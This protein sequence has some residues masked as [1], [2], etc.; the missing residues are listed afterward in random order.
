MDMRWP[1]DAGTS[2]YVYLHKERRAKGDVMRF[3]LLIFN[4][5]IFYVLSSC[6]RRKHDEKKEKGNRPNLQYPSSRAVH[7]SVL[8]VC[9]LLLFSTN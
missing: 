8:F 2:I 5:S 4:Y 1:Q 7:R 6:Q 3:F 9:L